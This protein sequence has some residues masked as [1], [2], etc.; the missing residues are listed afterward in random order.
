MAEPETRTATAPIDP[1]LDPA[2]NTRELRKRKP[3][4][5][6]AP[7]S[8]SPAPPAAKVVKF[9]LNDKEIE[10]PAGT[11][12][13]E[14]ARAQGVDVPYYCYHPG[15]TPAGNCRMCLVEASNS[16]KP[17]TACTTPV[18]ALARPRRAG[19]AGDRR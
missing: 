17:I 18:T 14:A 16:K 8:A 1:P 15:L 11:N 7:A 6:G 19:R 10:V 4:P 2:A 9:K 5:Y 12:L 13:I 3:V